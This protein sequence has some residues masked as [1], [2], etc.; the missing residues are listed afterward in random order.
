VISHTQIN[1]NFYRELSDADAAG[2]HYIDAPQTHPSPLFTGL[3]VK[4]LIQPWIAK[5][6]ANDANASAAAS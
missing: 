2:V 3:A 1:G 5:T 6:A 4:P